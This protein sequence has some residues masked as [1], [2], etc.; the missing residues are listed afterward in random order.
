MASI[1]L[2]KLPDRKPVKM[3]IMISPDLKRDLD[4]YALAYREAYGANEPLSDLI[5]A[6][7]RSF[8]DGDR[9][10]LKRRQEMSQ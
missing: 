1:K 9:A 8:L 3:A 7:L 5:S 4:A 2:G 10:F 6:M